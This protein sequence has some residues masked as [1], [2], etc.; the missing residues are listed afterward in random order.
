MKLPVQAA[1][2]TATTTTI[3]TTTTTT[4]TTTAT[5][6]KAMNLIHFTLFC[7]TEATKVVKTHKVNE[8]NC[9]HTVDFPMTSQ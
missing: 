3:T 5:T 6:T 1:T 4:I 9:K 8:L 7:Q 2:T